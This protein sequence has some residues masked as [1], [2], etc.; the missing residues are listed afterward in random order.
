MLCYAIL[1]YTIYNAILN[2]T[3]YY[4]PYYTIIYYTVHCTICHFSVYTIDFVNPG[5]DYHDVTDLVYVVE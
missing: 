4:T 3:L 5:N 2:S 1:C